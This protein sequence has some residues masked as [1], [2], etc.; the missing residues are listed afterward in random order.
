MKEIILADCFPSVEMM[1][2]NIAVK[3]T[4]DKFVLC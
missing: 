3:M 4:N 1:Y 2:S